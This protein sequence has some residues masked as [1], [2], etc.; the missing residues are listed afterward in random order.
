MSSF[1]GRPP[2]IAPPL[3]QHAVL[4]GGAVVVVV[5]GSYFGARYFGKRYFGA[6]YF[7]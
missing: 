1:P 5:N 3:E 4:Y 2:V 6:R 7:N